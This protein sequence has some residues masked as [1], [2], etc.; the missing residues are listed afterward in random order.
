VLRREGAR[1]LFL[2]VEIFEPEEG[3]NEELQTDEPINEVQKFLST[4]REF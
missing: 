2:F 4:M 3:F 1:P